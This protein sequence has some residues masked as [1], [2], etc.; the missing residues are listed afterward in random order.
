MEKKLFRPIYCPI[1][2]ALLMVPVDNDGQFPEVHK[3]PDHVP[4]TD[5][6]LCQGVAVTVT[7][8]FERCWVCG[9]NISKHQSGMCSACYAKEPA[10]AR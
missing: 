7:L 1:C 4:A 10:T 2:S 8:D 6:N 9:C 3:L 5:V